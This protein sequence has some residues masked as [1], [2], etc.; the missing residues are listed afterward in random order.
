MCTHDISYVAFTSLMAAAIIAAA[1]I[2]AAVI[3]A[4]SLGSREEDNKEG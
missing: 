2:G 4:A 1:I 3:I